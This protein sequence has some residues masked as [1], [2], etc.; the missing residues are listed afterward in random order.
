MPEFTRITQADGLAVLDD[1]GDDQDFR[2]VG[3]QELFEH[4][5][6]QHAEAAAEGD[7]L[8]GGD[9][10]VAEHYDVVIQMRAVDAREVCVVDR[11]GQVQAN[12]LGADAAGQWANL[13]GLGGW[14]RCWNSRG[15]G[16][17][18]TPGRTGE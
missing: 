1:V 4:V 15:G 5:D 18:G 12:D 9:A 8:F 3:Q 6:L 16:H 2:V 14:G 7:L 10:L 11:A 13:E 17:E